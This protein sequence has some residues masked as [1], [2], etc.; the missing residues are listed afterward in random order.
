MKR[1]CANGC[2]FPDCM[3]IDMYIGKVPADCVAAEKA[4]M[5]PGGFTN[6]GATTP[7]NSDPDAQPVIEKH[8]TRMSTAKTFF[9]RLLI[10]IIAGLVVLFS[11][12][13][14]F[15]PP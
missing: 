6:D 7:L 4:G 8:L 10:C 2:I 5:K 1:T 11:L 13:L 14:I 3:F 12:A 9:S 15:A